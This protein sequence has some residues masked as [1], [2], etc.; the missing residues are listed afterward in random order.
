MNRNRLP[1]YSLPALL[2]GFLLLPLSSISP[3]VPAASA[4]KSLEEIVVYARKTSEDKQT[5]PISIIVNT[6]EDLE[7]AE[8]VQFTD[9]TKVTPGLTI[10][11][12]DP[13]STSMKIRGVGLAFFG[14]A[15]D[16]GVV[17]TVD[18]F[19]QSRIGSVFGAFLDVGQV[20][21]LK[22]PQ[23]TLYGRNAPSGVI[24]IHTKKPDHEGFHGRADVSSS[25]FN[26]FTGEAAVNLPII[27]DM[28]AMRL[29]YLHNESDGFVDLARYDTVG[30][31]YVFRGVTED[32][33]GSE[34]DNARAT[35]LFEPVETL[36]FL[37][38][39]NTSDYANGKRSRVAG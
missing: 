39:Y 10:V 15:A 3:Q 13:T 16:P 1:S 12:E 26:T 35:L 28:L 33:D 32:A 19:P 5:V 8:I 22:G 17:I 29:A 30:E 38:R 25:S 34:G 36:S 14:L 9:L 6:G 24:S 18:E 27:D 7:E 20:E 2:S 23:G 4:G 11:S 31:D 37:G 21:V